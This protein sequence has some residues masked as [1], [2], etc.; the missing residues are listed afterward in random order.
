MDRNPFAL[1]VLLQYLGSYVAG[2]FA[3]V[4]FTPVTM[5]LIGFPLILVYPIFAIPG[6]ALFYFELSSAQLPLGRGVFYWSCFA[7]GF[8]PI[9]MEVAMLFVKSRSIKR[10]RPLW[11]ALPIGFVG[12]VGVYGA[13]ALSV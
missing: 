3:C 6:F 12:T 11:I 8:T 1:T 13:A 7:F 4:A 9:V 10:W 5:I 2:V